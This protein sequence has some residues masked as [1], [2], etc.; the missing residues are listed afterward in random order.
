MINFKSITLADKEWMDPIFK[1]TTNHGAEY[2]FTSSYLWGGSCDMQVAFAHGCFTARR[3]CHGKTLYVW[4]VGGGDK[5]AVLRE[6]VEE[7]LEKGAPLHFYGPREAF[8]EELERMFAG[9]YEISEERQ[10]FDYVYHI[11]KMASLAGKKLHGKR[12][13]INKFIEQN[14]WSVEEITPANLPECEEMCE[15][16]FKEAEQNTE[17]NYSIE[18]GI[19]ERVFSQYD[20]VGMEGALLRSSGRVIAFTMGE[21]LSSDTYITH[22]EKAYGNIQGAYPMINREFSKIVMTRYPEVV[23]INREDD[24]GL[25]NLRKAKLSYYP[26]MLVE[27]CTVTMKI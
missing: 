19:L 13:H 26:E 25:E 4:P 9:K 17:I 10:W 15:Q 7:T 16:W 3:V 1:S 12:N 2:N 21:L 22:F 20:A 5:E 27:K 23:Y 11:E 8:G 18:K 14:D 6:I 24:M